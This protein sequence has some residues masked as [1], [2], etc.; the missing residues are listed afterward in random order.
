MPLS[1]LIDHSLEVLCNE[2]GLLINLQRL[3]LKKGLKNF[4][5]FRPKTE[6]YNS[7]NQTKPEF[8][9]RALSVAKLD[10]LYQLDILSKGVSP[11]ILRG[12]DLLDHT[13]IFL[14]RT[15]NHRVTPIIR[16]LS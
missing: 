7:S 15:T 3:Y 11:F 4:L 13:S 8:E 14:L 5:K 1:L 16:I 12:V 10:H 6:H 9:K 2:T